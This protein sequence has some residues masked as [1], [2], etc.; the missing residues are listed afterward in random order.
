M[1]RGTSTR[2][3]AVLTTILLLVC[4][5]GC[6]GGSGDKEATDNLATLLAATTSAGS[7]RVNGSIDG[8]E[9]AEEGRLEGEWKGDLKGEGSVTA[10][11]ESRHGVAVPVEM[12]WTNSVLYFERSVADVPRSEAIALFTRDAQFPP[13]RTIGISGGV[14]IAIPAAFSPV[15]LLDWLRTIHVTLTEQ[16]DEE[17]GS[18]TATRYTSDKP[19]ATVGLWTNATVDVW[20]DHDDRVIR[21]RIASPTGGATYDVTDF[22]SPVD[23]EAPPTTQISTVS[24]LPAIEPSAPFEVVISGTDAGVTWALERAPGTEET[25]CW[26][27]T[28]T[29]A[30]AQQN[31]AGYRCL[32]GLRTDAEPDEQVEF[33]AY[34]NGQGSYDALAVTLPD[35]V[36]ELGLGF[37]GST[38]TIDV[39]VPTEETP[40]VWVGPPS[41][42]KAYLGVTLADGSKLDCGAGGVTTADDLINP[43]L[44]DML[45]LS[46]WAC[47]PSLEE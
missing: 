44:T 4:A 33:L 38:S 45:Y 23:V 43:Q 7:G 20:A 36:N 21:I 1:H 22:G 40:L 13:W 35:G 30:L 5:A 6:S 32:Q 42:L 17:V 10:E 3:G 2:R 27:F 18:I 41:P 47:L 16:G 34:G 28:A 25:T 26:R 8:V 19:A 24:E 15:A 37:V 31:E 14:S 39:P 11:F 46:A 9:G 12:V 29:P